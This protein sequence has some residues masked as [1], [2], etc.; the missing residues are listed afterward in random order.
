MRRSMSEKE[1]VESW[2][3]R[4]YNL[5]FNQFSKFQE[6]QLNFFLLSAIT[7]YKELRFE[8]QYDYLGFFLSLVVLF[9]IFVFQLLTLR[10]LTTKTEVKYLI[11]DRFFQFSTFLDDLK[12]NSYFQE[13]RLER[14]YADYLNRRID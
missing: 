7:Q 8:T 10:H 13:N 12:V 4:L 11:Q 2:V 6:I 1:V 5:I 14:D 9:L 3:K